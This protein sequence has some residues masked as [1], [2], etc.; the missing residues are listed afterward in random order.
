[1]INLIS[2]TKSSTEFLDEVIKSKNNKNDKILPTYKDRLI[3]LTPNIHVCYKNFDIQ[4]E[5][6]NLVNLQSNY[7]NDSEK[8][9][10]L[11]LYAYSSKPFI[12]LK[13]L[14][15]QLPNNRSITTCQYCT[16]SSIN[17]F[18]HIA[19]KGKFPEY[20][21]H[22]KN[23][24]PSCSECNSKKSEKWLKNGEQEFLN[25]YINK[26]PNQKY[27]FV[28][29]EYVFNTFEVNFYLSNVNGIDPDLYKI[30][31][32]HYENLNLLERFRIKSNEVISE[33]DSQIEAYTVDLDLEFVLNFIEDRINIT[34][35][36]LGVNYFQS[37]IELELCKG[38]AF[39]NYLAVK[40]LLR[41]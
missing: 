2:Y 37:V 8:A 34:N 40:R 39:K 15:T 32:S 26:L 22:P 36:K 35:G 14:L 38:N 7:F 4:H 6:K 27:L 17:T 21:I 25:L 12:K 18:D 11:S 41:N 30:I 29:I 13:N 20:A 1:M 24:F 3:F 19:P 31:C 9:D 5:N 23:L 16:I 33:F 28:K 10:L